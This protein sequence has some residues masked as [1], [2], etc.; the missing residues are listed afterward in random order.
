VALQVGIDLGPRPTFQ[1]VFFDFNG[2]NWE[3]LYLVIDRISYANELFMNNGDGT[4]ANVSEGSGANIYI[5]AMSGTVSDYDQDSDLDI[6]VANSPEGN[7]LLRNNYNGTFTNMAEE[8]GVDVNQ[9]CWGSLFLDYDN[10][11]WEDLFVSVTSPYL[12]PVGNQYF[13]N[14]NGESFTQV[15]EELGLDNDPSE[16]YIMAMGDINNDGYNDFVL[17][18]DAPYPTKMWMNEGGEHNYFA[19]TVEGIL[20]NRDG[21][22]TTVDC[23]SGGEKYT[24]QIKCG[25]NYTS[26]NSAR[27]I[28]GLSDNT[29]VDSIMLK[30]NS[31]LVDCYY[32]LGVNQTVHFIEG[33]SLAVPFDV[34]YEG[35]NVL[36]PGESVELDAGEFENYSWNTGDTTRYITISSPG[37]YFVEVVNELGFDITSY[38]VNFVLNNPLDVIVE[39]G[40]VS[41][42]G[43]TTGS[44][45]LELSGSPVQSILWNTGADSVYVGNLVA[46]T[47]NYEVVYGYGCVESGEITITQ[48]GPLLVGAM[49]SDVFCFGEN[50]GSIDLL[51][52]GGTPAYQVDWQN[53]N[54]DSLY[55]GNYSVNVVDSLN[56]IVQIEFEI[57]EPGE[58]TGSVW[59]TSEFEDGEL[60]SATLTIAGGAMPYEIEWNFSSTGELFVNDIP[61]GE[62]SVVI[63]DENG[64]DLLIDFV[65][66]FIDVVRHIGEQNIALYPNPVAGYFHL[67][68]IAEGMVDLRIIGP[69][70]RI[71][72]E[73]T[74]C[75]HKDFVTLPGLSPGIYCVEICREGEYTRIPF[76]VR[77][78]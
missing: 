24:R 51:I 8:V 39:T 14:N 20:S 26:Q 54:P 68:G 7:F 1:P 15:N 11:S 9:V 36:C 40:N 41:C 44:V 10:D 3:D 71:F 37:Q 76:L 53:L 22:G 5:N 16:T 48:P 47:Y 23:Y 4:F 19:F 75:D 60:G 77:G 2:D 72:L 30:W 74:S 13:H 21:V 35:N 57:E 56:C 67:S 6:Y 18:N 33:T 31:G 58:L 78:E 50:T 52:S 63:M 59:V 49:T 32:N 55:A 69:D 62:Y 12:A 45:L 46:G 28:F 34:V 65:I 38:P 70:G 42:Y 61:A 25:E 73:A 64:C 43:E 66:D 29:I 27:T 17:N